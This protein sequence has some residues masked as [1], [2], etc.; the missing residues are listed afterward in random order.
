MSRED[1]I[2]L[3][4]TVVK[5][6]NGGKYIVLVKNNDGKELEITAHPTGKIRM[7]KVSIAVGDSVTVAVSPYDL[8]KGTI[9]WR[10]Q[11]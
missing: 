1:F 6:V 2:E 5:K 3:D 9:I 4:G 8:T 11:K 10:N 7:N